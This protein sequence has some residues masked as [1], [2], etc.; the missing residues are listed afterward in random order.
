MLRPIG[1]T[2]NHAITSFADDLLSS[3][4]ALGESNVLQLPEPVVAV[5]KLASEIFVNVG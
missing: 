4:N 1:N 3:V 5:K 2:L